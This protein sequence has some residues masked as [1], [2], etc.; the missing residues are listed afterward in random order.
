[1]GWRGDSEWDQ[2]VQV[3]FNS[4]PVPEH[5]CLVLFLG[6]LVTLPLNSPN[7]MMNS[8]LISIQK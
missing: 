4:N 1:M 3:H 6:T 7:E 8:E 5:R 2:C